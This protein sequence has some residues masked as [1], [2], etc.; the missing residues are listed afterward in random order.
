MKPQFHARTKSFFQSGWGGRN[1]SEYCKWN[2]IV[3]NEAQ[4]VTEISTKKYFYIPSTKAHIQHFNV[5]AFP[6]LISLELSGSGLKGNIPSEISSLK[7]LLHLDLSSNFL[8]GE[9]S[10]SL[11]SLTQLQTLNISNNLLTGVIPSTLGQLKNLILL[12]LDS[13]QI[14]GH[15]PSELGSLRG[16][17]QLTLSNNS[18]NGSIPSTLEHLIHLKVLDLSH[19]KISGV[20][21]EGISA[22]TEL[23]SVQLSWN[24][25]TGSI[26]P[27]IGKIL[28]L[29]SLDISNNHLQG[30]VPD[31]VL[32]HCQYLQL[33]NNSLN[34]SIP[35]QVGNI[36][37]LDLSYNDLT[38]NIPEALHSVSHLNLSYNSFNAS[39]HSFCGFPKD[40]LIGNKGMKD[41]C[42]F[43][44][45]VSDAD[46]SLVMILVFSTFNGMIFSMVLV[47]WGIH[48]FC[49]LHNEFGNEQ[50]RKNGDML[51][52]WNYD[53]KIAFE[54]IIKA[55][56]DFDIRY[57]IGTGAYGSVYKAELPSGRIVALKKLHEAESENPSSYKSFCN[58]T[59]ILTEI[60]HRNIIKLYGFCLHN[61]CMF[62]VYEYMERGSL[63]CNLSYDVEAQELNWSKRINV[64]K[65]IAYGLAHM[66]HDCTPPIVHRDISSNNI[67]LNSELQAF[68][69]DFGTA[70]LLDLHSSNQTLPAGTYGYVAPE[71][72]YTLSVTTKCD[73]YSFGVVVL[74][75]MM[76]RHPAELISCLSEPSIQKKKLKDILDS[77]I[78]LP[79]FRKDMQDIVLVV[80]LA[81]ACLS[82]HPKSRPSMQ[83]IANELLAS[84]PPLLWHFDSISIHQLIK[85]KIY[86]IG[87]S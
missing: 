77:R 35:S 28:R 38:G 40:S 48:V 47:C 82:P 49:P 7:K 34:G 10:S 85:Q 39:D 80:T 15:I 58:E 79:H 83:E 54:D 65:G 17:E 23:T 8:Q 70:R 43:N 12:S 87:R 16:L 76:G 69:S 63:F 9:L 29:Q 56:E 33:R 53:G 52:I 81:L 66:H 30:H 24:Q 18:L 6:D 13:N 3:C 64:V 21:P 2:G 37:Y 67:L 4:S 32:E 41:S 60:R 36:S 27:G 71:L 62:L 59:K 51:S 5:A 55:T 1:I 22:L 25:I 42:S 57:C 11:S 72:A 61:K 19:N 44:V 86:I 68:I 78:P 20:I 50:R 73:V 26:P 31:D 75:T 74:E 45:D 14:N 84:K 46:I